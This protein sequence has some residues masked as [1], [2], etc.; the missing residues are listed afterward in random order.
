MSL[1]TGN[2]TPGYFGVLIFTPHGGSP[3]TLP[4]AHYHLGTAM[5]WSP[6]PIFNSDGY[7][8]H[9]KGPGEGRVQAN[10]IWDDGLNVMSASVGV[11]PVGTYGDLVYYVG[12]GPDSGSCAQAKVARW[13][14]DD[15]EN[16]PVTWA[17]EFIL[18]GAFTSLAGASFI[19]AAVS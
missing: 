4:C 2:P 9:A 8:D 5:D 15:D 7:K 14:V 1:F 10:G 17:V 19:N 3:V 6:A 18:D 12:P 16:S 13:D 11:G